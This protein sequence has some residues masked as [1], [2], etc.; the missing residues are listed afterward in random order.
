M[1]LIKPLWNLL[2]VWLMLWFW[3][4]ISSVCE[5]CFALLC[6]GFFPKRATRSLCSEDR[7]RKPQRSFNL[8]HLDKPDR[9]VITPLLNFINPPDCLGKKSTSLNNSKTLN[10]FFWGITSRLQNFHGSPLSDLLSNARLLCLSAALHTLAFFSSVFPE[11][12][13]YSGSSQTLPSW[14]SSVLSQPANFGHVPKLKA[15][16]S[17]FFSY[18]SH[19]LWSQLLSWVLGI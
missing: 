18:P 8:S 9:S 2:S 7:N 14:P 15:V 17:V 19:Q 11:T 10:N 12:Q 6:A 16:S 3:I 5:M 13:Y 1:S 4:L